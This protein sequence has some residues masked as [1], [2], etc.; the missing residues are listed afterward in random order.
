[1]LSVCFHG[2]LSISLFSMDILSSL[3]IIKSLSRHCN[4]LCLR[5]PLKIKRKYKVASPLLKIILL[6]QRINHE[7]RRKQSQGFSLAAHLSHC[8]TLLKPFYIVISLGSQAITYT[9]ITSISSRLTSHCLKSHLPFLYI[10]FL[11]LFI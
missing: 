7:H 11:K 4:T 8:L 3:L 10:I 2:S 5:S 1:M 9:L 6:N